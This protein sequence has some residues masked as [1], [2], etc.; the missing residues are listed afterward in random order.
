ML[1]RLL[2]LFPLV[3][4][5]VPVSAGQQLRPSAEQICFP[6]VPTIVDCVDAA[7]RDFW[8]RS[9]GLPVFGYPIG[10]ALPDET[11]RGPRTSQHFE[12]YRL[13]AHP[14][15]PVPY[16]VQLGRLGAERLAQQGR[17]TQPV[18]KAVSGCRFFSQTGHNVCGTFLAYW[19]S[20]GLELDDAGMSE[21]ESLALLGLPLT[22]PTLETNSSGDRVLTQWFERARLEDHGGTILQG[23]LNVEARA[24]LTPPSPPPGFVT[25]SGN[26]LELHGQPVLLKGT[27][28]YPA[29][30]PWGLMWTEWDGPAVDR[31]LGRARRELGIN[32]VRAL[33]PYRTSEGWTDGQGNIPPQMLERLRQFVQIA[34]RHQLKV[35]VTLF[36]WH[37][38]IAAAGSL[39]EAYDL[40]YLRTIV[41][42]FKD[43]DRVLAWD[44]HNE[45][46]NY[47]SWLEGKA[48][49]V[50]D[51][52]GRMADAIRV[53]D[54]HHPIT[55]G[56]G[57][58]ESLWQ[59]A[60]SGRT[61]AQISDIISVHEYTPGNLTA[62]AESIRARTTKPVLLEE[63]GWASGPECRNIF[64]DT[65]YQLYL[66]Y[67]E[68]SQHEVYRRALEIATSSGFVGVV[69]WWLQDPPA[70]L[71]YSVD[72]QGHFGLYRR[73]GSPKPA[74]AAFRT[75]RVPALHSTTTSAHDLTK[76]QYP[77]FPPAHQPRTFD[78]G[79]VL[80]GDFKYF[81][82]F[83]GGEAVFGRPL[84]LAYRDHR[85][86]VVQYFERARF[87]LNEE[88]DLPPLDPL[89]AE[90]QTPD[91]YLDRVHLS[92]LGRQSL[93]E[94]TVPRVTDP[95]LPGV[96]YFPQTGHTL[97][98]AFRALWETHGERFYGPPISEEFEELHNGQR[99]RV[100]YFTNWR[101]ERR[102]D[103]PIQY[104][105]LGK[106]LLKTRK[107][108]TP[109]NPQP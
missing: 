57:R 44:L 13:E 79:I 4:S 12:R 45:P 99:V 34:G 92:P 39:E 76:V 52:L 80:R 62:I 21:R 19:R 41:A 102:G 58:Y 30:H 104:T 36:D 7:F 23:L 83:F 70:T 46:D 88:D 95:G 94:Q 63:F 74:L 108:P 49:A 105:P 54:R 40:R 28:Y 89:W 22:E 82:D 84:T 3:L 106:D 47:G 67:D 85:G 59:A 31:E 16:T 24:A 51:W 66:Y 2:A 61:I 42:A 17:P 6:G 55:V 93:G 15:L 71:P 65:R 77:P 11:E 72:E 50:V 91:I 10:P 68:P 107:C 60:P 73:D 100:Q 78:D 32:T 29:E 101:F 26:R 9:G 103:G 81:W 96:R 27:N 35:I 43:D 87:E 97:R 1:L 64:F 56:V 48:P 37:D 69:G 90:G 38:S 86:I 109:L 18:V 98:G 14:D 8:L 33:V 53:L 75:L 25:I 20:H 5:L